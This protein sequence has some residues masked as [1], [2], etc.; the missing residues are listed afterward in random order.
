[1]SLR[2]PSSIALSISAAGQTQTGHPG[3]ETIR[4]T[5]VH[6]AV[7]HN[8]ACHALSNRHRGLLNRRAAGSP[9]V[10]NPAEEPQLTAPDA[11]LH[12]DLRVVVHRVG[13]HAVDVCRLQ[14]SVF[15]CRPDCL[16]R[17]A[18]L[19]SLRVLRELGRPDTD[20]RRL[21][22]QVVTHWNPVRGQEHGLG[23]LSPKMVCLSTCHNFQA[24]K[25]VAD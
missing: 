6:G 14:P 15:E 2:F 17:K 12:L 18:Q 13:R 21:V 16:R 22:S 20:D 11:T 24:E 8:D 23:A 4:G 7:A 10:V 19:A 3:P 9:T 1:M 25:G 5:L